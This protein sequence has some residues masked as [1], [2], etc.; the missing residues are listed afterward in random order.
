MRRKE[1]G[2]VEDNI[3]LLLQVNEK[4][5]D[6]KEK[7][8]R[9]KANIEE[10][11]ER[12]LLDQFQGVVEEG[13]TPEI[14]EKWRKAIKVVKAKLQQNDT[15]AYL[16]RMISKPKNSLKKLRI[17]DEENKAMKTCYERRDIENELIRFNCKHFSKAKETPV[18]MDKIYKAL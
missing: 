11:K 12:D 10:Y 5:Q 14:K 7:W 17:V 13:K 16:T 2:N 6:N 8:I 1:L 18:Y 15:F 9:F 3:S 4:L